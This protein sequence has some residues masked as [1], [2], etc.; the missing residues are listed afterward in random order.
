[1]K[2]R[3]AALLLLC[4][5]GMLLLTGCGGTELA[6]GFDEDTIKETGEQII[7]EVHVNNGVTEVLPKYMREDYLE[8]Y[9]MENMQEQVLELLVGDGNFMAFTQETVIGK[10]SPEGDED[11]AVLAVTA[12][13]EKDE[14][15]FTMTF[16]KDMKL[17]GFYAK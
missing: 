16:D 1:M 12:T 6:E 3:I 13:Y 4:M 15:L 14:I 9:P 7:R 11:R 10:K 8:E 17:V 2:R 5:F